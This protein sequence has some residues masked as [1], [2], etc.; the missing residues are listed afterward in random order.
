M[1]E[2]NWHKAHVLRVIDGDTLEAE[3]VVEPFGYKFPIT[4]RLMGIQAPEKRGA[5][6]ERGLK[7]TRYV[8]DLLEQHNYEITLQ[9]FKKGSFNRWLCDVYVNKKQLNDHLLTIG[10]AVPYEK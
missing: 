9:V 4:I 3:F 2:T 6:K 8:D 10:Y 1:M 7:V 5:S